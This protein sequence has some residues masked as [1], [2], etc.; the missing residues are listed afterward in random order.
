MPTFTIKHNTGYMEQK[1]FDSV[2]AAKIYAT[3]TKT[4]EGGTITLINE[5]TGQI[6]KKRFWDMF[7]KFGW[8]DWKE[9]N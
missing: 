4:F 1:Q 8:E 3:N 6:Y 7:Y 5:L 9:D 2:R